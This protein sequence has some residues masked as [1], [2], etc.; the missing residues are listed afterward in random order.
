MKYNRH[1]NG[2]RYSSLKGIHQAEAYM[3]GYHSCTARRQRNA[4]NA[5]R[6]RRHTRRLEQKDSS[7][8]KQRIY[9]YVP[10]HSA[11]IAKRRVPH[12]QWPTTAFVIREEQSGEIH[13]PRN[14]DMQYVPRHNAAIAK[15]E[16]T[17]IDGLRQFHVNRE[18]QSIEDLHPHE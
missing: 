7:P 9:R 6:R 13:H 17:T 12:Y 2:T 11:A 10:R 1:H 14:K 16:C 18:E 5:S 4:I 15:R 3:T 8:R